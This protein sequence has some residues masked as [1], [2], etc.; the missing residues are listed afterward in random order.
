MEGREETGVADAR[1][2]PRTLLCDTNLFVRLLTD[3]PPEQAA[4]V[5]ALLERAPDE[6][7]TLVLT[8]VVF[9]ELGDVLTS[10]YDLGAD[11]AAD[12]MGEIIE[13][14][15]LEVADEAVLVEAL[16]I[17]R[18]GRLDLADAYLA[19]LNRRTSG[20]AVASFDGDFD[21]LEG[22]LRLDPGAGLS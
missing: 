10:V 7:V 13:L 3:D 15:A 22:V 4:A 12:R 18:D 6:D 5:Q 16:G 2:A 19:A 14:R 17:W 8:D 1:G 21:P 9:V 11:E 20:T